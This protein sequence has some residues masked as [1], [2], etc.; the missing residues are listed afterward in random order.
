MKT[1]APKDFVVKPCLGKIL[2]GCLVA[3][4]VKLVKKDAD[5]KCKFLVQAVLVRLGE[6]TDY[7]CNADHLKQLESSRFNE[8][9]LKASIE[10]DPLFPSDVF[11]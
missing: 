3:V 5:L 1:T 8:I 7:L 6:D 4:A 10:V 11:K 2:P 9:V